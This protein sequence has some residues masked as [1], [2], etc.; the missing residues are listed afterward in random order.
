MVR[1]QDTGGLTDCVSGT[2]STLL[3]SS[4]AIALKL[5][6]EKQLIQN[7]TEMPVMMWD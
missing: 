1:I 3:S 6:H 2:S 5:H 4:E 7:Q